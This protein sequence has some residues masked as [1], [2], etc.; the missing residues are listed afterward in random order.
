MNWPAAEQRLRRTID[1][2]CAEWGGS[3]LRSNFAIQRLDPRFSQSSL[4]ESE[5]CN[6]GDAFAALQICKTIKHALLLAFRL[7]APSPTATIGTLHFQRRRGNIV[8][9]LTR[10]AEA[11][12]AAKIFR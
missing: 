5:V 2:F 7:S 6:S 4:I 12:I 3:R 11:I 9:A 8:C 1:Y 10:Y